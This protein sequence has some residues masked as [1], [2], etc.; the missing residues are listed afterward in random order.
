[1]NKKFLHSW[2]VDSAEARKIQNRLKK[3]LIFTPFERSNYTVAGIDISY[4]RTTREAC[5]AVV[6]MSYPVMSVKE[7]SIA[8]IPVDFP[9][10][11]GLLS[12]REAPAVLE[13]WRKLKTYPD[14][15]L[16]NGQGIAH[17]C[18][19]GLACHLGLLL[20]KPSIGCAK[21][22]LYGEYVEPDNGKWSYSYIADPKD[23][24]QIGA[25]M[26]TRTNVNCVYTSV[27]YKM[28]LNSAIK[29]VFALVGS[30]RI[31]EPLK[32]AHIY[33]KKGWR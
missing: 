18:R 8:N 10:I 27:G 4:N 15:L 16:F 17:P 31:P 3:H 2:T 25:V 14:L 32:Q 22:H 29:T 13:A 30:H 7:V 19:F 5:A 6:V 9:Y 26:R 21:D 11:P 23:G 33:S 28:D 12:F 20:D 24:S 1:V